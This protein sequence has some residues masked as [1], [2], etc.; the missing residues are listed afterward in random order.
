MFPSCDASSPLHLVPKPPHVCR[1]HVLIDD[2]VYFSPFSSLIL[3]L[4]TQISY[5]PILPLHNVFEL[6]IRHLQPLIQQDVQNQVAGIKLGQLDVRFLGFHHN[7]Q[8]C[9]F[10]AIYEIPIVELAQYLIQF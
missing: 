9:S 3:S 10:L 5:L 7:H 2:G 4:G 6:L 8:Y 1:L